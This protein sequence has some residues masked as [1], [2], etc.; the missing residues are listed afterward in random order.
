MPST[1]GISNLF[2]YFAYAAIPFS[3]GLGVYY[4]SSIVFRDYTKR[5]INAFNSIEF[6][7][8]LPIV[9]IIY[10]FVLGKNLRGQNLLLLI[11]SY[12]FYGWWDWQFLTLILLS[13]IVDFICGQKITSTINKA[14]KK[15]FLRI[16][17]FTNLGILGFLNI[18]IF[19]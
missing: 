5:V 18:Q 11:A 10:W 1:M 16:S 7:I 12:F 4:F 6:L 15:L 17:I 14:K 9:F 3:L 13:T 2:L 19:C 8:F